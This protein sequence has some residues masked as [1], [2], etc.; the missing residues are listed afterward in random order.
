LFADLGRMVLTAGQTAAFFHEEAQMG[1]PNE[2]IAQMQAEGITN[3]QDLADFEKE[4]LQ[5]LAD[6]LRKPG[7][8]IP[9]PNP[10]AAPGATI[11]TP[12]FVFGAKSQKRLSVATDLIKYY[13]ATGRDYTAA[14]LQWTNVVKNFDIQWKALKVKQREDPPEIPK[15]SKALPVIKWTEAFRDL[16]N[17]VIGVRTIPLCYVIRETVGV[18]IAAPAL[19]QNQPHSNDHESVEGELVA[20]ASHEFTITW[21]KQPGP[22]HMLLPSNRFSGE[23]MG[24]ELG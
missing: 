17:R 11:P 1:I 19:A 15:L 14:N 16:L 21:K 22:Q 9:D 24:G 4:S 8:R 12:A 2:T 23:R 7:G 13:D 3:V 5:Q 6:N 20:R 18:P 10:N